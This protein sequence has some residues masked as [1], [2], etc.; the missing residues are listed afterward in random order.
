MPVERSAGIIIYRD[1]PEG[2]KYLVLRSS[3]DTST[4]A[5]GKAVKEFWDVPKGQLE[6]GETGIQAARREAKEEA[7]YA[8]I[9][10][11]PDFKETIRY[12]T[13]RTGKPVPKF[14][15]LF[16]GRVSSD[17]VTLSWEHD[18]AEWLS[19]EEAKARVSLKPMKEAIEKAEEYLRNS[20]Q[21]SPD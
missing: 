21:S 4:L 11:V 2:R 20:N 17:A 1:T 9:E 15:A 3:R 7:G 6:Q 18:K 19:Y 8:D 12:F 5:P 10:I 13:M 16:L 14:V